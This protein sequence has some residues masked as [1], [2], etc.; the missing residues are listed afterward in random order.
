ML[1]SNE[2][3]VSWDHLRILIVDDSKFF[4]TLLRTVIRQFGVREIHE[5]ENG[6]VA[7]GILTTTQV[8]FVL[9]DWHMP[10][11]TGA[12]FMAGLVDESGRNTSGE[13]AVIVI[14]GNT[15]RR[16]VQEAAGLG[17]DGILCKPIVPKLLKKRMAEILEGKTPKNAPVA[18]DV[19]DT[20]R[21]L[22]DVSDLQ[23][24]SV[25]AI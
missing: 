8:D 21:G 19:V 6:E 13:A 14:T 4:R 12:E 10:V 23:N 25:F 1:G 20:E 22:I 17:V 7:F 2:A 15:T 18:D 5:A 24:K 16:M 11:C 9:L 3:K